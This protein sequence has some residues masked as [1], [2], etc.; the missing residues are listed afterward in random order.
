M[1][2]RPAG[3]MT[4][5]AVVCGLFAVWGLA[6]WLYNALFGQFTDFF[7]LQPVQAAWTLALFNISYFVL[8]I[9][10]AL[11]HRQF[12][13][14]IGFLLGLSIFA[15]GAFLLYLAIIQHSG[16]CF[17]SAVIMMGLCG[18]SLDTS[19]NPLAVEAGSPQ[20]SVVRLNFANAFNGLG[21]V[22]GCL[23]AR[24]LI[25]A[26]YKLTVGAP[27]QLSA[28][29]Y[30]L[31]GLGAILLAYVIE[32][33]SL[34]AFATDR[35][36]K[37]ASI[38]EDLQPLL[39]D[40]NIWFAS[41]SLCA[42]FVVLTIIWSSNPHYSGTELP[43]H[44]VGLIEKGFIWF[45]IGRCV[46]SVFM[47]WVDPIRLLR[48]CIGLSFIAIAMASALGGMYG[49]VCLI[50]ASLFLSITFPTIFGT[51]ICG[52]GTRTK[53]AAGILATAAGIG[54]A[55]APL[56]VVPAMSALNVRVVILLALPFLA[57]ILGYALA[58]RSCHKQACTN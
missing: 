15:L 1:S 7:A 20:T 26:H 57:I 39:G 36:S 29:P 31:I 9:P 49:W 10:A 48:W 35:A 52:L 43:G 12:G 54:N 13:Y 4:A 46:G 11:F 6:L 40:R 8:A 23:I 28:R 33:M 50:S 44:A 16:A 55:L 14:K 32:Q 58:S 53:L 51:A 34:P 30:V 37:S 2:K 27:A 41:A 24:S 18:A 3:Q 56:F 5:L 25:E 47:C 21:L 22:A 19:L 45:A 42:Y 38:R 17:L